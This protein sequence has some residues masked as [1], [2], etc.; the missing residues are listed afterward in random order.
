[1]KLHRRTTVAALVGFLL[2]PAAGCSTTR[3]AYY[4]AWENFGGYA[5]RER[6]SDNVKEARQEQVE[7][8]EQFADALEQFR[9][10][11]NFQGSGDLEKLYAKLQREHQ[12]SEKQAAS[13]RDK[14]TGV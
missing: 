11:V 1:M 12:D 14:I 6:L 3:E 5:K 4:N 10:V 7:A 8:K 13:V 9:S 2:L